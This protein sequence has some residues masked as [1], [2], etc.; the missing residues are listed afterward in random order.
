MRPFLAIPL[1][2][3]GDTVAQVVE[4]LASLGLPCLVVDDGSGASTRRELARLQA[5]HAWLEVERHPRNRGRGAALRTAY[6]ASARRGA[7]HVIQL[8]ADGQHE[9]ADVARF[10]EAARAQP[11]A[12]ILGAPVFDAS[13]P[14]SR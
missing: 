9:V 6:R 1:Y 7:T 12:L 8:D 14:R 3:H 4:P 11:D 10:V 2:D 13:A 5:R